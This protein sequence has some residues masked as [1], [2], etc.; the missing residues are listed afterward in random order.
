[1]CVEKAG[2]ELTQKLMDAFFR[3]MRMHPKNHVPG[4]KHSEIVILLFIKRKMDKTQTGI[5]IGDLSRIM[6][7]TSPTVTQ[8]INRLEEKGF[9]KR[10]SDPGDRRY[11]RVIL[12]KQ[13]EDVLQQAWEAL[14]ADF[15]S[16]IKYLGE[17]QSRLLADLLL[18]SYDF[19]TK[20]IDV[21]REG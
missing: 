2:N 12:T 21:N 1:M 8:F 20:D 15:N 17:E 3:I 18:K 6:R 10:K 11:I 13:G 5:R 16:L 4:V 9:V 7:V 14:V 19:F